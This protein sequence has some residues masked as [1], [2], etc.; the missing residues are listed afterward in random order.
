MARRQGVPVNTVRSRLVRALAMLRRRLV[1]EERGLRALLPPWLPWRALRGVHPVALAGGL[2]S[3]L[4]LGVMT[5]GFGGH[6][7]RVVAPT[8]TEPRS[9]D[10]AD[11]DLALAP[12]RRPV[13]ERP[14]A[15]A[16]PTLRVQDVR[17]TP[18]PGVHVVATP[19]RPSGAPGASLPLAELAGPGTG[20]GPSDAAG[21]VPAPDQ[22]PW[23]EGLLAVAD[24]PHWTT[25]HAP[26]LDREGEA[27]VLVT[28]NIAVWGEV[29]DQRS[30]PLGGVRIRQRFPEEPSLV[31]SS[32]GRWIVRETTSLPDGTFS[33]EGL[34]YLEGSGIVFELEGYRPL[35]L[36]L[37]EIPPPETGRFVLER[38]TPLAGPVDGR[39]LDGAG[40]PLAGARVGTGD[41]LATTDARGQFAFEPR[42][43]DSRVLRVAAQGHAPVELR[44]SR[45]SDVVLDR[46]GARLAGLLVDH[47]GEPWPGVRV[48]LADPTVIAVCR[49]NAYTAERATS[50]SKSE[51]PEVETGADGRFSFSHLDDRP[52]RLWLVDPETTLLWEAGPFSPAEGVDHRIEPPKDAWYDEV[53]G[54]LLDAKGTPIVGHPVF[55]FST[56][57]S[58]DTSPPNANLEVFARSVEVRTDPEGRFSL[59]RVPRTADLFVV[60]ETLGALARP[61]ERHLLGSRDIVLDARLPILVQ[62]QDE[63]GDA[64]EFL[65]E[66]GRP[67]EVHERWGASLTGRTRVELGEHSQAEC[68]TPL[69]ARTLVLLSDGRPIARRELDFEEPC[70]MQIPE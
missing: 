67:V 11:L 15:P 47:D 61:V 1:T 40:R 12:R 13:D 65:D 70:V 42:G 20:L 27:T 37:E 58:Y 43:P 51:L 2:A 8:V 35:E 62:V 57:A 26:L 19:W 3:L 56:A 17:G 33:L 28:R 60:H 59:R 55:V 31:V 10:R 36:T 63:A 30:A 22:E 4:V 68:H 45:G 52:Y 69:R 54:R 49:H 48:V 24:T 53:P 39:V 23:G 5:L 25:V 44:F 50:G 18:V 64:L 38:S 9:G 29:V 6:R 7:A 66:A 21:L 16:S 32:P 41:A 14:S 46:P 34:S